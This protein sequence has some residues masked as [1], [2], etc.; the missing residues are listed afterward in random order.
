MSNNALMPGPAGDGVEWFE[1][2]ILTPWIEGKQGDKQIGTAF[3]V[4][5]PDAVETS[6]GYTYAFFKCPNC[7]EGFMDKLDET[8]KGNEE[9]GSTNRK[10][11]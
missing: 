8:E 6:R 5:H 7:L 9:N 3:K 2:T 11:D 10:T 4:F 1:C